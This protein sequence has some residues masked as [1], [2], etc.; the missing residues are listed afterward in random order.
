MENAELLNLVLGGFTAVLTF[1][2]GYLGYLIKRKD[3]KTSSAEVANEAVSNLI[4]R[5]QL[6]I[7]RIS[8]EKRAL[9]E[10]V[11]RDGKRISELEK[12]DIHKTHRMM[13][14]ESAH[15]DKPFPEWLKD[16]DGTMLSLNPMYEKHFLLP[17]GL[18]SY[19]Y[20]GY[21]DSAAWGEFSVNQFRQ[22]DEDTLLA[23]DKYIFT[24]EDLHGQNGENMGKWLIIKFVREV[25]GIKVGVG[26]QCFPLEFAQSISD[27]LVK[28]KEQLGNLN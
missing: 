4:N 25:N 16:V 18:R 8:T 23:R 5:L 28:A 3:S 12:K 1:I 14:L 19:D 2:T 22:N 26:G 13:L 15:N 17:Q 27:Q 9:E 11:E 20:V 21:T 7:E 24:I 10:K 6:E